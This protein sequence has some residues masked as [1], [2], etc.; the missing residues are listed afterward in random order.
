MAA[1]YCHQSSF[2]CL[3]RVLLFLPQTITYA[4]YKCR[5][6]YSINTIELHYQYWQCSVKLSAEIITWLSKHFQ[7]KSNFSKYHFSFRLP[8]KR[9]KARANFRS[10][11]QLRHFLS[12]S[13]PV[14]KLWLI[15]SAE[16]CLEF[17]YQI[18]AKPFSQINGQSW[19]CAVIKD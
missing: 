17:S 3:F 6:Q 14:S 8:Q 10:Q 2:K 16:S 11:S 12:P 7:Q 15:K 19:T 9:E 1:I 5:C 4:S 18:V 13:A